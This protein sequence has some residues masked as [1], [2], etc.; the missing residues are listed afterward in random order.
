MAATPVRVIVGTSL[1]YFRSFNQF[2]V[3]FA[4]EKTSPIV[5]L[6]AQN[7]RVF[8]VHYSQFHGLS[9]SLSELGTSSKRYYKRECPLPMSLPNINSDMKKDANL[10]YYNFN[11][12]GIKSLFFSSY[13]DPCILGP[14][15][16]FY[17]YRSGDHQ[18]KVNGSLFLIATWKYGRCQEGRKRQIYMSG[19]WLWRMT[20]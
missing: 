7:Y 2:G 11:P 8:S 4:V 12:M 9:Y 15:T 19:P 18:K 5:A 14:I 17:C 20:H 10:D 13:G 1:G 16:R 3:P 6:T